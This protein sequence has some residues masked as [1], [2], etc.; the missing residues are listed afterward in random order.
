VLSDNKKTP[1]FGE[2]DRHPELV[3]E[4]HLPGGLSYEVL[5]QVRPDLIILSAR[6]R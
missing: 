3:S 1:I 5:K 6:S 2:Y 4:S